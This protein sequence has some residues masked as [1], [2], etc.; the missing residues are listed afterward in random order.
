VDETVASEL[1]FGLLGLQFCF[2]LGKTRLTPEVSLYANWKTA[3]VAMAVLAAGQTGRIG[4][5][6]RRSCGAGAGRLV[7]ANSLHGAELFRGGG[8]VIH[9]GF[10]PAPSNSLSRKYQAIRSWRRQQGFSQP[11]QDDA[12]GRGER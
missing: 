5:A 6:G 7:A 10:R 4:I 3:V 8:V 11:P 9:D 12:M 2:S 1:P